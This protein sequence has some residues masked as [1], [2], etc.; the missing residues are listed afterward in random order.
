VTFESSQATAEAR[1]EGS[2]DSK[3]ANFYIAICSN[4]PVPVPSFV[5]VPKAANVLKERTLHIRRLEAEMS[6]KNLWLQQAQDEHAELVRL[7]EQQRQELVSSNTWARDSD[8]KLKNA[9]ERIVALQEELDTQQR[10]AL[11]TV[12][13]FQAQL[14]ATEKD[15]EERTR[16][17]QDLDR[18]LQEHGQHNTDE[19]ARCVELLDKAEATVV[20]R[21]EWALRLQR[22]LEQ[23]QAVLAMVRASRWIKLGRMVHLGPELDT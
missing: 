1:I 23:A 16:W 10:A 14:T 9:L 11:E 8:T 15:L 6:E 18:Q 22:E 17:A 2:S 4:Y 7:H 20:E 13:A 3:Q 5:Y 21:T 19:L 12:A